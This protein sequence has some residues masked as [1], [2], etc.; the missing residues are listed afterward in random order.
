MRRI[1]AFPFQKN[2]K[3]RW[4]Y[5]N[6]YGTSIGFY[7]LFI[8]RR[9][10]AGVSVAVLSRFFIDRLLLKSKIPGQFCTGNPS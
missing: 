1:S 6:T 10:R 5:T 4:I 7:F 9:R 2:K 3:P 8:F